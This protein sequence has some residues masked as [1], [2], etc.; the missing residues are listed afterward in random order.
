MVK[1][2]LWRREEGMIGKKG[3]E[4]NVREGGSHGFSSEFKLLNYLH[5]SAH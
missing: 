1:L 2:A 4:R 3:Q 5:P